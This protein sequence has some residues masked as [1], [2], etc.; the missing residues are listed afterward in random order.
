MRLITRRRAVAALVA[1]VVA[2]GLASPSPARAEQGEVDFVRSAAA[3][4]LRGIVGDDGLW[5][6]HRRVPDTLQYEQFYDYGL[7]LDLY[8][9]FDDLGETASADRVYAAVVEHADDYTDTVEDGSATRH[10]GAVAKLAAMVQ[11]HGDDPTA[12]DGRDLVAELEALLVVA[13]PERGWARDATNGVPSTD[14]IDQGWAVR[15]LSVARSDDAPAAIDFLLAQQCED[16]SVPADVSTT[17]CAEGGDV[18]ATAFV[19]SSLLTASQAGATGVQ[20][21]IE[22]ATSWLLAQQGDDGSFGEDGHGNAISTGLA[23]EAL[24]RTGHPY[25]ANGAGVWLEAHQ[26]LIEAGF[27]QIAYNDPALQFAELKAVPPWEMD[28]YVRSTVHA[29]PG[30]DALIPVAVSASARY[31][32]AAGWVTITASGLAPGST[33][34][35]GVDRGLSRQGTADDQGRAVARLRV[36]A[37]RGTYGFGVTS[38]NGRRRAHGSLV[39]LGPRRLAVSV[40]ATHVKATRHQ[41][42]TARGLQPHEPYRV[43]YRGKEIARGVADASGRVGKTFRVGGS[44]GRKTVHVHGLFAGRSGAKT[45]RVR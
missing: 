29:V 27:G 18:D 2:L 45:F 5:Q 26:D 36:S 34:E 42:V 41:R 35:V 39:V 1:P 15:A 11:R 6:S 33:F 32:K 38:T 40:R 7:N 21:D 13:G 8:A 31:V 22:Q 24:L 37:V 4:F 16:G 19:I 23:A 25:P 20:D 12:V 44:K 30:L 9:A 3:I 17:P 10:A 28:S 43:T 14:V